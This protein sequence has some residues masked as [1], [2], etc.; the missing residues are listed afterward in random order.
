LG[1]DDFGQVKGGFVRL[2]G[3]LK[4]AVSR[5]EGYASRS[6]RLD[7]EGLYESQGGG[8]KAGDIR[9]DIP[10]EVEE[11]KDSHVTCLCLHPRE[12]RF[13]DVVRLA[14]VPTGGGEVYGRVG[15]VFAIQSSWFEDP[16]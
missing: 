7:R 9:Y 8:A 2:S 16:L 3:K 6:A 12:K 4:M 14:L 15:L 13:G 10:S 1:L 5:G 11:N